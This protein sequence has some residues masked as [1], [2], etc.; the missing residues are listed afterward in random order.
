V[1]AISKKFDGYVETSGNGSVRSRHY[2]FGI[3]RLQESLRSC[4]ALPAD[5]SGLGIIWQEDAPRCRA[6]EV[7]AVSTRS[8]AR[9][10]QTSG[11]RARTTGKRILI[12]EFGERPICQRG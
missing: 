12:Q 3:R 9:S 5:E 8:G 4:Q 10:P 11:Y 2:G 1:K 6:S 7:D